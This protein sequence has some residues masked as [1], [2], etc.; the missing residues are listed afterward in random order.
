VDQAMGAVS[1]FEF[2]LAAH[3]GIEQGLEAAQ[4]TSPQVAL[5]V[6]EASMTVPFHL[7][8]QQSGGFRALAAQSC[9]HEHSLEA[10]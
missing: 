10:V 9:A 7:S 1:L 2:I 6:N 3:E 4:R 8:F 5:V